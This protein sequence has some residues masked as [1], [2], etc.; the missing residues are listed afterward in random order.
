MS[1]F[2]L[3]NSSRFVLDLKKCENFIC[4][5]LCDSW[6]NDLKIKSNIALS[7]MIKIFFISRVV[8]K[9]DV[10][11]GYKR[12]WRMVF[13]FL[14][15]ADSLSCWFVGI[16]YFYGCSLLLSFSWC[17]KISASP[18]YPP[19]QCLHDTTK[20]FGRPYFANLG[21]FKVEQKEASHIG[22]QFI[23]GL[24]HPWKNNW[25]IKFF[26]SWWNCM[27]SRKR[28]TR[29]VDSDTVY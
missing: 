23:S 29:V 18:T 28:L 19:V 24:F 5:F 9:P 13:I 1:H 22:I 10:E 14:A 27:I 6:C 21:N 3:Q 4:G 20:P 16:N 15:P 7:R 26:I 11:N 12:F 17:F 2:L 25:F 8:S